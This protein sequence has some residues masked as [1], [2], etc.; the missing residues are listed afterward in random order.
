MELMFLI[1]T[2][3]VIRVD[4]QGL[5]GKKLEFASLPFKYINAFSVE[6]AGTLSR[7]VKATLFISKLE[8]GVE[9]EFGKKSTDIFELSNAFANKIMV[10]TVHQ[11]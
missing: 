9:T 10:H 1:T 8:G 5:S 6:S 11:Q 4:V 2:K 7:S 3:R